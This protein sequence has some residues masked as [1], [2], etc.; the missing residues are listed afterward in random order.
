MRYKPAG[1]SE[2]D[3]MRERMR[4]YAIAAALAAALLTPASAAEGPDVEIVQGPYL[5]ADVE[6]GQIIE[7]LDAV[8]PWYPASTTKMMTIYVTFQAV[9]A[10]EIS[11]A[12]EIGYS[13]RAAAQPPSKMGF[14]PGSTL[15]LDHALQILMVKSAND[16]AVAVAEAVGGSV[17]GFAERMNAAAEDLGMTRSHFV[18]PH[19]LPDE[20][21]IT[22]ARDMAL[23]AQALL[24][25]FPERRPYYTIHAI[26]YGSDILRNYN[27]LVDR[28]PGTTGMKTGF[29]CASG[30]N[31]VASA[32]RNGRELIAVVFGAYGGNLRNER[33]AEL[34]DSAFETPFRR[35]ETETTLLNTRSGAQYDQPYDMRPHICTEERAAALALLKADGADSAADNEDAPSS[36]L[37]FPMDLGPP[38]R[39]TANIP[40]VYGEP[41][42][43]AALPRP[44]PVLYGPPMQVIVTAEHGD[45]SF[46][47]PLPRPRPGAE[48]PPE[49]LPAF[50]PVD[51]GA[52]SSEPAAA[53]GTALGEPEPLEDVAPE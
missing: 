16:V 30:Y 36:H 28:Y 3:S 5:V 27:R 37:T 23:L 31:L 1:N 17:E 12:E 14:R 49:V 33:A 13:A 21:Q 40:A 20:R 10:N 41:G 6:T 53:I 38:L 26:Q 39:V 19:G 29:I 52:K 51:D 43:V 22:S 11:L 25:E 50:A 45:P 18:N 9:R 32:E 24:K 42:Y 44:R 34:L 8:R 4:L 35:V 46:V 15:T 2:Q 7:Q 48:G 47:A